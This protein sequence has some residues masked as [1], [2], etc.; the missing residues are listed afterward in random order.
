M[1]DCARSTPSAYPAATV[2]TRVRL[3]AVHVRPYP[4]GVPASTVFTCV[5]GANIVIAGRRS[6]TPS[7]VSGG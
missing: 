3:G 5:T 2:A 6:T 7:A 1:F 4:T